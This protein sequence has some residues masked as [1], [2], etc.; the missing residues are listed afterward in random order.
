MKEAKSFVLL[1]FITVLILTGFAVMFIA[2]AQQ[3]R[4]KAVMFKNNELEVV[5]NDIQALYTHMIIIQEEM[6]DHER[7]IHKIEPESPILKTYNK[8]LK[9][10]A[11]TIK[12]HRRELKKCQEAQT[13]K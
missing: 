2:K 7:R 11:E 9:I 5:K 10:L 12:M 6:G 3:D 4:D 8:N 13:K 1:N